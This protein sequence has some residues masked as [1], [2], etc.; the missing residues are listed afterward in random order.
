MFSKASLEIAE[1]SSVK[2]HTPVLL[3]ESVEM[4]VTNPEG[5]YIDATMG[6]AGHTRAIL[7]H[8]GR[9]GRLFAFDQDPDAA[10]NV[11]HDERLTFIAGNFRFLSYWMHYYGVTAVDGIL[12]DLGV[13]SHHFDTPE[14]GFSFRFG[15]TPLDMRMNS[16]AR[17]TA[18]EVLASYDE[19]SLQRVFRQYGE[20]SDASKITKIILSAREHETIATADQFISILEGILPKQPQQR[21]R[22]LSRIFQSLR[23]E[24]ND[25][26][27]AL[28]DFLFACPRLLNPGGR[29]VVLTYHSLED[30]LVKELLR[31]AGIK[32]EDSS[33]RL[34]YGERGGTMRL[35]GGKGRKP[36]DQELAENS[37]A[38][39]AK[40]RVAER[41]RESDK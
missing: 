29:I 28:K 17:L 22:K 36:S 39:S 7:Q 9:H 3:Q 37:R 6:G 26:L 27:G 8:I 20:L 16:H 18:K 15:A 30:R 40:M 31:D 35:L 24:V 38:S 41:L 13:S 1:G 34:I 25:E 12:A 11:P 32:E 4:L 5:I 19:A 2:Y 10:K 33:E 14:R 23:I 21:H